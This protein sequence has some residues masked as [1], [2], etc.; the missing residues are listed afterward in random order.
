MQNKFI[1]CSNT[2][3]CKINMCYIVKINMC[4]QPNVKQATSRFWI[5]TL[6][7]F[8]LLVQTALLS[9]YTMGLSWQKYRIWLLVWDT[10]KRGW[11]IWLIFSMLPQCYVDI[12]LRLVLDYRLPIPLQNIRPLHF[13]NPHSA[14]YPTRGVT[15]VTCTRYIQHMWNLTKWR[16]NRKIKTST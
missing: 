14:L 16:P 4:S 2:L 9:S 10:S 13:W 5:K 15:C 11:I 12:L 7:G 8:S 1:I 3:H 6:E